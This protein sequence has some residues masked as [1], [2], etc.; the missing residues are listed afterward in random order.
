MDLF[1]QATRGKFRFPSTKGLL[2]AEQ[3]WDLPLQSKTGF[4]LDNV[5]QTID[6]ELQTVGRTSFVEKGSNPAKTELE[7][8]LAVVVF[9]IDTIQAEHKEAR[10][11]AAKRVERDQLL[12]A[13]HDKRKS[14][15][16]G[17]SAEELEAR[18]KALEA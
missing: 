4:S 15:I 5:A 9:V 1:L 3:L 18:I 10:E 17:L 2:T 13:L 6:A 16:L 8:K 7:Q 12:E 14:E 11:K